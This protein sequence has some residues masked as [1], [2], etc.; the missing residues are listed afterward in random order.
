MYKAKELHTHVL[1]TAFFVACIC[2]F[3][4]NFKLFISESEVTQLCPTLGD[5]ID[6]IQLGSSVHG[7]SPGKNTGVGCHFLLQGIFLTQGSDLQ[8]VCLMHWQADSLP[9]ALLG[10]SRIAVGYTMFLF[11]RMLISFLHTLKCKHC[12]QKLYLLCQLL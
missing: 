6:C 2:A 4:S 11:V 9:L 7:D 12:W 3:F 1:K 10:R 8:L 5:L